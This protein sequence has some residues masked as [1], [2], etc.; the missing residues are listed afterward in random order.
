MHPETAVHNPRRS[1]AP[2]PLRG[3]AFLS[4][5]IHS[6]RGCFCDSIRSSS[7]YEGSFCCRHPLK[8]I[9]ILA[10]GFLPLVR[11]NHPRRLAGVFTHLSFPTLQ[12]ADAT[13]KPPSVSPTLYFSCASPPV[14]TLSMLANT[15]AMQLMNNKDQ[16]D[17][18]GRHGPLMR[19]M[20]PRAAMEPAG[21]WD[22]LRQLGTVVFDRVILVN[23]AAAQKQ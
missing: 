10:I 19:A 6:H 1:K 18:A 5:R 23:R 21:Y 9:C 8:H 16:R 17:L 22:D 2:K 11:G 14:K 7:A 13:P 12:L 15:A 3:R 20:F 4:K